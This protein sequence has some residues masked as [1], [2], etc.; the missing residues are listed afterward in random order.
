MH[1]RKEQQTLGGIRRKDGG[2]VDYPF[3]LL[4]LY[5]LGWLASTSIIL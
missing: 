3:I 5:G 1:P 4:E 2:T